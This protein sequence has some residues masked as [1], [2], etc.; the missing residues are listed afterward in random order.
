MELRFQN[1][2]GSFDFETGL[3][4]QNGKGSFDFKIELRFRN[5]SS[6]LKSKLHFEMEAQKML[7]LFFTYKCNGT[8]GTPYVRV[9][10]ADL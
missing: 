6:I 9:A 4:F 2:K 1:G 7:S 5:Q 10:E 3:Q 8:N